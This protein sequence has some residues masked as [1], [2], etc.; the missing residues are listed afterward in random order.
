MLDTSASICFVD[1]ACSRMYNMDNVIYII[2][3]NAYDGTT[4]VP[5]PLNPK[6]DLS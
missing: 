5:S 1:G 6:S 3:T 2:N 4:K